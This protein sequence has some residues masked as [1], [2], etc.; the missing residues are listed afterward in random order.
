M[1]N[2]KQEAQTQGAKPLNPAVNSN[3]GNTASTQSLYEQV[4]TER[5]RADK[6][7]AE[8]RNERIRLE[9]LKSREILSGTA[10]GRPEMKPAEETPKEY[11]KRIMG[12]K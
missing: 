9:E 5:E 2:E 8:I 7:L 1:I 4:R 3:D 12:V 11:A 6:T 10:G